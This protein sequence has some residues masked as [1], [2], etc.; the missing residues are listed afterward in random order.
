MNKKTNWYKFDKDIEKKAKQAI[1]DAYENSD[2]TTNM[3][4]DIFRKY[5]IQG[6]RQSIK[7]ISQHFNNLKNE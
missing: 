1:P 6:Y 5:Y 2:P 3:F 7:D 4:I